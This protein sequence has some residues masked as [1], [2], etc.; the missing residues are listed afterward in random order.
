MKAICKY[1]FR[2]YFLYIR[3]ILHTDMINA[4]FKYT[5]VQNPTVISL[6]T[7]ILIKWTLL[8]LQLLNITKSYR[9]YFYP[10]FACLQASDKGPILF[11]FTAS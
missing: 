11:S 4:F 3:L 10:L 7:Y 1:I 6:V 2:K 8:F 9:A 5:Q